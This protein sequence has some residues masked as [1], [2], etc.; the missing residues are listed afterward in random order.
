M[1][2]RWISEV[3]SKM[4]K[5]LA[6]G[7]V[8]AGQRPAAPLGISTDS[9][10]PVRDEFRF[11]VGPVRDRRTG[12]QTRSSQRT[13]AARKLEDALGATVF[14]GRTP[15][16]RPRYIWALTC[17]FTSSQHSRP[18]GRGRADGRHAG[19]AARECRGTRAGRCRADTGPLWPE[20]GI[21]VGMPCTG[22]CGTQHWHQMGSAVA[23]SDWVAASSLH[24]SFGGQFY[25][26]AVRI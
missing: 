13:R 22:R 26:V 25:P 16:V 20:H 23:G 7:A 10:R 19:R 1:I 5:I 12:A 4:V 24:E 8:S 3:P 2:R 14:A 9:A 11:W 15:Q 6:I 18:C 21:N 17:T